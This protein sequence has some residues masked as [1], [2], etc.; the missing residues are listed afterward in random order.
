MGTKDLKQNYSRPRLPMTLNQR[1]LSVMS[2]NQVRLNYLCT[3]TANYVELMAR[4]GDI[5]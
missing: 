2:A 3:A 1:Q 4:S 5:C